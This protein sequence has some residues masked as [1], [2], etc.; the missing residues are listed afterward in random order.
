M[1]F[2]EEFIQNK[3]F[4]WYNNL[5][6]KAKSESRVYISGIHEKHHI[7]P[8]CLGGEEVVMLTFKEHYVAHHLLTKFTKST[9]KAKM[10]IAF[11][12]F[13]VFHEDSAPTSSRPKSCPLLYEKYRKDFVEA[14]K[15]LSKRPIKKNTYTFKNKKTG[16]IFTGLVWE[17]K[18]HSGLSSVEAYNLTRIHNTGK[19]FHSKQWGIYHDKQKVFSCEVEMNSNL[20]SINTEKVVCKYCNFSATK[21]NFSRWKHKHCNGLCI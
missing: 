14:T 21:G 12:T 4:D 17:F 11:F 2:H 8:R 19:R 3:Y 20:E 9:T 13:F 7:I 15:I 6:N 10:M 5:I 18:K 1:I 16:E